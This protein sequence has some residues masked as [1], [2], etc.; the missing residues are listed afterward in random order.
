M[1]FIVFLLDCRLDRVD[2]MTTTYQMAHCVFCFLGSVTLPNIETSLD[3]LEK[4]VQ[5]FLE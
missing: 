1:F 2:E 4:K 3:F 5:N